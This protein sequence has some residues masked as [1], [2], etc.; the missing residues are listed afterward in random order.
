VRVPV[1]TIGFTLFALSAGQA[2]GQTPV[3]PDDLLRMQAAAPAAPAF[4][5]TL[6][7]GGYLQGELDVGAAG[8]S[9]FPAADRLFLRRARLTASGSAFPT[10]TYRLQAEFAGGLA[11]GSGVTPSLTDGYVEWTKIPQAH[12]RFGQFKAPFGRE[13]LVSSTQLLTIERSLVSDRLTLNRQIGVEALG[14]A[15][16]GRVGYLAAVVNGNGRNTT[17]NDNRDFMYIVRGTSTWRMS[18]GGRLDIGANGF[19]SRDTRLSMPQEFGFDST[20]ETAAADNLFTGRHSGAGLDE[21]LERGILA[22]DAEWLRVRFEQDATGAP[23]VTSDGW[24]V[25]PSA[26]VFRRLLQAVA[27]YTTYRPDVHIDG[28]ETSAWLAGLNY[29]GHGDN[30]KLMVNYLWVNT[31]KATAHAKLLAR[32]QVAF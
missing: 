29:Y 25:M 32:M 15:Y 10:L 13:W 20:A 2:F 19:W 4:K 22:V 18:N 8:D 30:A 14:A 9:R 3:P 26:F 12:I 28:N 6:T 23:V 7:I 31:P 16:D 11:S 17:V 21:H 27:Q 5:P 24:Y 1:G